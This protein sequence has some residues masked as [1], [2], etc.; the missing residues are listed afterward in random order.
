MNLWTMIVLIVAICAISD[1]I[2]KRNNNYL[3]ESE[4]SKEEISKFLVRLKN[5]I[6][7]LETIVLEQE[8]NSRFT[9]LD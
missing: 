7:N 4:K 1:I 2:K 6:E 5:R 3:N 9:K 8:R